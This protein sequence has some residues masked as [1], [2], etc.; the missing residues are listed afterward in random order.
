[1]TDENDST[2]VKQ[3]NSIYD[4]TLS[5]GPCIICGLKNYPLSCGG[6]NICPECDGGN[7]RIDT[8]EKQKQ[9]IERLR[10]KIE[11]LRQRIIHIKMYCENNLE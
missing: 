11:Y 1:M 5:P 10:Q 7:F 8:I 3:R 2:A 4:R 6:L 9:E